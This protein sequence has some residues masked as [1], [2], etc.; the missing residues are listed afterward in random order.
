M[1][2]ERASFPYI[3]HGVKTSTF[4]TDRI[5]PL[6]LLRTFAWAQK[7]PEREMK[8]TWSTERKTRYARCMNDRDFI[9]SSIVVWGYVYVYISLS[10]Y[11]LVCSV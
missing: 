4:N 2:S 6:L 7:K 1:E 8:A 9:G 5:L 11:F 10:L 3:R